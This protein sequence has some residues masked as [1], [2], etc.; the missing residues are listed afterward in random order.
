MMGL[1]K[2][3]L[4]RLGPH[5]PVEL[6]PLD[7][8]ECCNNDGCPDLVIG[9][10]Y[11]VEGI[12]NDWWVRWWYGQDIWGVKLYGDPRLYHHSHFR[13]LTREVT[14]TDFNMQRS[15]YRRTA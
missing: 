11:C 10:A 6:K 8:V 2:H 1:F 14:T 13:H 7:H 4:R 12:V 3:I 9:S 5:Y 15:H